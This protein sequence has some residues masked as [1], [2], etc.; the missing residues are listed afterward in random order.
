MIN[1]LF[2]HRFH[3]AIVDTFGERPSFQ[4]GPLV[5]VKLQVISKAVQ[6]QPPQ[7]VD[8]VKVLGKVFL[9]ER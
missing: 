2:D 9:Y 4:E 6:S 3:R 7:H 8:Y 5:S 1:T